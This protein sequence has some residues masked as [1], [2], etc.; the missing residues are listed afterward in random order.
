LVAEVMPRLSSQQVSQERRFRRPDHQSLARRQGQYADAML[1]G[2]I[3][4][5]QL[6]LA[7]S[8]IGVI[9]KQDHSARHEP[10]LEIV[11]RGD[12]WRR[13]VHV[14]VQ[15]GDA[16]RADLAESFR[17]RPDDDLRVFPLREVLDDRGCFRWIE[18]NVEE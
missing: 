17:H 18:P 9:I 5:G 2:E 6:L 13:A 12:L 8:V 14:E 16:T 4:H 10:T 3:I 1:S 15:I 11:N 7:I